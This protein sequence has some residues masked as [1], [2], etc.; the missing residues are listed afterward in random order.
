MKRKIYRLAICL[1]V[2][3]NSSFAQWSG[4]TTTSGDISRD[5]RVGIGGGTFKK[6]TVSVSEQGD[7]IWLGTNSTQ[8]VALLG[9]MTQGAWNPITQ[10]GDNLLL[11]KGSNPDQPDAGGLVIAPWSN[12]ADGIRITPQGSVGI[13]TASTGSFKLAVEGKIGAR[14]IHVTLQNPFPDY[15]FGS[16]Y[17]LR[18]LSSLEQ[19]INQ[20][21]HLPGVP[22]ADEVEKN[23]GVELGKLNTKLLEKVEELTLYVIELKKENQQMKKEIKKLSHKK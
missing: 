15:V 14:E 2:V 13:G 19:Y 23:G 11:W 21:K 17:K 12:S 7:G 8:N 22:S 5:G 16:N 6:L 18:S 1:L 4:S 3:G 10:P 20:N 9:N